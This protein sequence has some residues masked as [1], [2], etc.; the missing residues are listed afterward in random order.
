MKAG[1]SVSTRTS[2]GWTKP[3]PFEIINE[4][5]THEQSN[6]FLANNREVLLMSIQG[7]PNFGSR[8]L[9]V[10]FLMDDG[11]WS[12]PLNLGD[13]INTALE[14]TSPFL[15]ADDKTLYFSSDGYTGY[16][17]HDIF[18]SRRLDDTWTKWSEPR[19]WGRRSI[20]PRQMLFLIFL[21][22]VNMGTSQKF[23]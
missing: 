16:G 4:I 18:V 10:S 6:Y 19:I 14:E 21:Q 9:Y 5:N 15:A 17:K 11:R 8:D 20:L 22:L 2:E 13:N 12:E 3:V 7:D 23:C 1:V